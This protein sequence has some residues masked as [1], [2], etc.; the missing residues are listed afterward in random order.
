MQLSR[1]TFALLALLCLELL[2]CSALLCSCFALLCSPGVAELWQLD[3]PLSGERLLLECTDG[4]HVVCVVP[5]AACLKLFKRDNPDFS[6]KSF[7]G[8]SK[9]LP[10]NNGR[11]FQP[12]SERRHIRLAIVLHGQM[13]RLV[14]LSVCTKQ[15]NGLRLVPP[16]GNACA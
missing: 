15:T 9:Q 14:S 16:L 5:S 13:P 11:E 4:R 12:I 7:L 6:A 3:I 10:V 2:P 1:V 8:D